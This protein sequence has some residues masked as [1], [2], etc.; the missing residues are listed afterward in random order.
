MLHPARLV[1]VS[2]VLAAC[3]P[4]APLG[5]GAGDTS[6]ALVAPEDAAAAPDVEADVAAAT[7]APDVAAAP[8]AEDADTVP[9]DAAAPGAED[10]A[11]ADTTGA[12][13]DSAVTPDTGPAAQEW[14]DP[15][16]G[17]PAGATASYSYDPADLFAMPFPHDAR[18]RPEGGLDLAGFPN[19]NHVAVLDTYIS[20][21]GEHLDGFAANGSIYVRFEAPIDLERLPSP[22]D[23]VADDSPVWLVDLG[24]DPVTRG[25]RVPFE[26]RWHGTEPSIYEPPLLL[27]VR[28]VF[29]F[30]LAEGR[31][32]GLIIRRDLRDGEGKL[33]AVPAPVHEALL[34]ASSL[35]DPLVDAL[36]PLRAW[37]DEG[38]LNPYEVAVATVFTVAHITDDLVAVRVE[39]RKL[40]PP[41]ASSVHRTATKDGYVVYEGT[42]VGPNWQHGEKPYEVEGGGLAFDPEGRPQIDHMEAIR[43]AVSV[44]DGPVPPGGWPIVL[45]G[46]GT[47]GNYKDFLASG[48]FSPGPTLAP[49]GIAVLGIDQPLH[50]TRWDGNKK[51]LDFLSFNFLNLDAGRTGFRQSA[52]D[53]FTL[54]RLVQETLE[55]P[56]EET[57]DGEPVRFDPA[58]VYYFGHSHGGLAGALLVAVEPELRGAVLS[59]AGGGLA[60]TIMLR[61]DPYDLLS[62][63]GSLIGAIPSELT[64]FH[65]VITL[66]QTLVEVTDP[67]NYAPYHV[68]GALRGGTPLDLLVTEGK[69]DVSTPS[70][71]TEAMAAAAVLPLLAPPVNLGLG[72]ELKGV[73]VVAS[74][75][76]SLLQ[77]GT[78]A[79]SAGLLAQF[80]GYGHFVAFYCPAAASLWASMLESSAWTG[81]AILTTD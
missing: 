51:Q 61:K 48:P 34:A 55:I 44:P 23:S 15:Y 59:G 64:T 11:T 19:P 62:L 58:R 70:V 42:Y 46:H 74:P 7:A 43:F 9:D 10:A 27:A 17:Q 36:A 5:A 63:I 22:E 77:S 71:T 69:D 2:L 40:P 29:G 81:E 14:A 30:P 32:Y 45:F 78:G 54:V 79:T 6:P 76:Q 24:D 13:A 4:A 75:V 1:L 72:L 28:P 52:A 50:G 37:C 20:Y 47:G 35:G 65:P 80:E 49:R 38:A 3:D 33:L 39:A 26:W 66:V 16:D 60:M 56:G 18:R 25:T 41:E 21:A 57:P 67:I 12:G 8:G 53:F 73:S 31:T 68:D